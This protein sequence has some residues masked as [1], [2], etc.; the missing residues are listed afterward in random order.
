MAASPRNRDE[1]YSDIRLAV[2][3][4]RK[5]FE[6]ERAAITSVKRPQPERDRG[7][8][9]AVG[10]RRRLAT[11]TVRSEEKAAFRW[12]GK[13]RTSRDKVRTG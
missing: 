12:K 7:H 11:R 13:W 4:K 3:V 10:C 2:G 1:L 8:E 6:W 9:A 5:G